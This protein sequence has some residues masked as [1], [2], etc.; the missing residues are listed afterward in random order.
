MGSWFVAFEGGRVEGCDCARLMLSF[1]M[2]IYIFSLAIA[3][4]PPFLDDEWIILMSGSS[5][6]NQHSDV[7]VKL[8]V[9]QGQVE[10]AKHPFPKWT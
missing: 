2:D 7:H 3:K 10:D 1:A 9:M 8:R 5:P 4:S 6:E